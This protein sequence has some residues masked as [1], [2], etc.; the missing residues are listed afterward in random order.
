MKRNI[1]VSI[2][3]RL[4]KRAR[5]YAAER[6]LSISGLLAEELRAMVE[7]QSEYAT[8][9]KTALAQLETGFP[10]GGEQLPNREGLYDRNGLR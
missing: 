7:R 3:A 1:T 10:M 9:R 6:G 2:D 5:V 4:L 8:A